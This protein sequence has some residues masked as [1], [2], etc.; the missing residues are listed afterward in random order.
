MGPIDYPT[1]L[2]LNS[3]I[4]S[5]IPLPDKFERTGD[6]SYVVAYFLIGRNQRNPIK[7]THN[8]IFIL[9]HE[10]EVGE[11]LKRGCHT[12]VV[13]REQYN[14]TFVC[15]IINSTNL[16]ITVKSLPRGQTPT[17][18]NSTC[19][20]RVASRNKVKSDRSKNSPG[21]LGTCFFGEGPSSR[22]QRNPGGD[23]HKAT[24]P[25]R[26]RMPGG[27]LK[28]FVSLWLRVPIPSLKV[29]P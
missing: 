12:I 16:N 25:R 29:A 11:F 14:Y 22:I 4:P 26:R 23:S 9:P 20:S 8:A 2:R 19:F 24:K 6:Y 13:F 5:G 1:C 18:A 17:S 15:H 10:C 28:T 27:N 3:R 21:R 7:T